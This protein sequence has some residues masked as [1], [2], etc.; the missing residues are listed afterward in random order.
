MAKQE[1]VRNVKKK[2]RVHGICRQP[3]ETTK[4]HWQYFISGRSNF[5]NSFYTQVGWNSK[6]KA[7][8]FKESFLS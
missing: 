5:D 7:F 2:P 8:F 1:P 4:S 6:S 3:N